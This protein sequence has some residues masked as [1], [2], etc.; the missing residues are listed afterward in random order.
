MMRSDTLNWHD[1][2]GYMEITAPSL[3]VYSTDEDESK[4]TIVLKTLSQNCPGNKDENK[5][6]ST[7]FYCRTILRTW[8][9]NC[10]GD[11]QIIIYYYGTRR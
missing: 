9:K 11:R 10:N 6:S 5:T 4:C 1:Y 3:N 8:T 7:K 2:D